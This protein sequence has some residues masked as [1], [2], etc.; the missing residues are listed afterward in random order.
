MMYRGRYGAGQQTGK[1]AMTS[2]SLPEH[3]QEKRC[4]E[5][6]IHKC[7]Y[8]LKHVHDVVE[9][10][11]KICRR[12]RDRY[13]KHS[14]HSPHPKVMMIARTFLDVALIDVVRPDGV[15]RRHIPGHARHEARHQ[16]SQPYSENPRRKVV[17]KHHRDRHI[18]VEGAVRLFGQR[19]A[20][21]AGL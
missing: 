7:E 12:Y 4:E 6:R 15:E 8:E 3:S 13:A 9:S 5:R 1:R 21:T 19:K 14:R 20:A 2:R 10:R 11:R 18:V 16:S 17:T